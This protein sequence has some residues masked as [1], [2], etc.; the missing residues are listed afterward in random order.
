MF[1]HI[2]YAEAYELKSGGFRGVAINK[3]TGA[4]YRGEVRE[5]VDAAK[6]DAWSWVHDQLSGNYRPAPVRC[7]RNQRKCFFYRAA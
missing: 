7:P 2:A 1:Q 6:H 4:Q 3:M 5:T